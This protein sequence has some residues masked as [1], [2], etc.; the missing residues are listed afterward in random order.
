MQRSSYL[1]NITHGGY[2]DPTKAYYVFSPESKVNK[3]RTDFINWYD[4]QIHNMA[5][6]KAAQFLMNYY[7]GLATDTGDSLVANP[8][9]EASSKIE[10]E[11]N[12]KPENEE[13]GPSTKLIT[14][15]QLTRMEGGKGSSSVEPEWGRVAKQKDYHTWKSVN[16]GGYTSRRMLHVQQACIHH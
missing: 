7:D 9:V 4:M 1:T 12:G 2:Q 10:Q 14:L 5:E 16:V 11:G 6:I 8:K 3:G 13:E 15:T